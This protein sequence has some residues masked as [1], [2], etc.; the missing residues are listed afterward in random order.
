MNRQRI[1]RLL[2]LSA[3]ILRTVLAVKEA[4]RRA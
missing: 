4:L 3:H 1:E 2:S